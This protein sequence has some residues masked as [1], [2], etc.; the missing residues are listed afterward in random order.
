MLK[1]ILEELNESGKIVVYDNGEGT[2]D[3]HTVIIGDDFYGMSS[4]PTE[5]NGFNQYIGS[6]QDGYSAGKHLG[7]KLSKI[8]HSTTISRALNKMG[9]PGLIDKLSSDQLDQ[10]LES[11]E[12]MVA[13]DGKVM[14]GIHDGSKR[15]ILSLVDQ[16]LFPLGQI[17]INE[18]ENEITALVSLLKENKLNFPEGTIFTLDAIQ[19]QVSVIKELQKKKL[20]YLLKVKGNQKELKGQLE[21]IFRQGN[22]DK[23]NPLKI[24]NYRK[25]EKGHDRLTT[26]ETTTSTDF[27]SKDLPTGFESVKTIGFIETETKRPMYQRYSGEKYYITSKHKTFFITSTTKTAKKLFNIARNHWRVEKLH[28]LKDNLFLEDKQTLK[29]KAAY[30]FTFIKSLSINLITQLSS[31]ISKTIRRFKSDYTFLVQSLKQLGVI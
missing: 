12:L 8:P 19:T 18:K 7:K 2:L 16:N 26:W 20:N 10:K 13:G 23:S 24:E 28:W 15:Q 22:K 29:G 11:S 31:E 25:F 5:H 30:L 1:E 3:R 27:C 4:N 17:E 9:L 21:Y 6:S 14:R